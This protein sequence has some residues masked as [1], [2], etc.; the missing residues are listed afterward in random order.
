MD[1]VDSNNTRPAATEPAATGPVAT[2]PV[3]GLSDLLR[4][5]V[6][7]GA[8]DLHLTAGAPPTVRV[9][10]DL[11][12][13]ESPVL[14]GE[15]TRVMVEELLDTGRLAELDCS[16]ES[17]LGYSA[18]GGRFRV[19]VYRRLGEFGIAIRSIPN[20]VPPLARLG[21]PAA[22]EALTRRP[23]G[24]VL[25]TGPTGSGKTTTLAAMI[26]SINERRPGH[27]I[28]VED[29]V[30]FVHRHKR[31][32]VNQR[33][34]GSD[35]ASFAEAVRRALRQDPDVI[36]IGE[37]RDPETIS[38]A[39]TAAETGHLVFATLHARD[40]G[41]AADRVI[42]AFPPHQQSQARAQ[43]AG[44]LQG[45]LAQRLVPRACGGRVAACEVLVA[46]P[47]V[48]NLLREQK[49]HQLYSA[50]QTGAGHGMQTLERALADLCRA[51]EVSLDEAERWA[52]RPDE[53]REAVG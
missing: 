17:D 50:M 47:G 39:L 15:A 8:S 45:V 43:L 53:L 1:R 27:I 24:L 21:L 38:T 23:G 2:G 30:E 33:E 20:S 40:C 46:T 51:G 29:P 14:T 41:Q 32:L 13:L 28:S 48:R 44:S 4:E 12:P 31:C 25:V 11:V 19:N 35:T 9:D 26:D 36:L 34:V 42:D 16:G 5:A 52:N 3:G 18:A 7:R 10:G 37:L 49:T 22:V 6:A